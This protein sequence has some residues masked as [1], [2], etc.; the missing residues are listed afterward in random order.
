M[1][2]TIEE[3]NRRREK[4]LAYNE[5]HNITPTAILQSMHATMKTESLGDQAKN[6]AYL[7]NEI[8]MA[9]DPVVEFMNKTQLQRAID[10][11]KKQMQ[12]ASKKMDFLEAAQLR[13]ELIKL[14]EIFKNKTS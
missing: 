2:K 9:A 12:E 7:Q 5:E 4:Q 11:T 6:Y 8:S 13:N 14:Q 3:T 1:R 10:R